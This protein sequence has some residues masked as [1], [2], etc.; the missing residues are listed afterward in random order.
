MTGLDAAA[1]A[2]P[3]GMTPTTEAGRGLHAMAT[4]ALLRD[5]IPIIEQE[6]AAAERERIERLVA[7]THTFDTV[8][9]PLIAIVRGEPLASVETEP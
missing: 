4:S 7:A 6:A 2:R 1:A 3:G 9:W 8:Y 5:L